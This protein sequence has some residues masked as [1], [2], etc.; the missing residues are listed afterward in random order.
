M[1]LSRVME[2]P[3]F[4]NRRPSAH[5]GSADS[6][7]GN[8][9]YGGSPLASTTPPRWCRIPER[10]QLRSCALFEVKPLLTKSAAH[11]RV[12]KDLLEHSLKVPCGIQEQAVI[13][14][15]HS[16]PVTCLGAKL[17]NAHELSLPQNAPGAP[18]CKAY[19][20]SEKLGSDPGYRH[21][22]LAWLPGQEQ[23]PS[24]EQVF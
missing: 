20:V 8:R 16:H 6:G 11:G 7:C 9:G 3:I 22:F 12:I 15:E 13:H 19:I 2:S 21:T 1:L 18:P 4:F 17:Q 5:P 23:K 10:I 24:G 14:P